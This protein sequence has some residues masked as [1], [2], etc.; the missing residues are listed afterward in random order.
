MRVPFHTHDDDDDDDDV[1][2]AGSAAIVTDTRAGKR[3]KYAG[4]GSE[5][6]ER[7][8]MMVMVMLG[9]GARSAS[10]LA[11]GSVLSTVSPLFQLLSP[12]RCRQTRF[13][14]QPQRGGDVVASE[15][16]HR[17]TVSVRRGCKDRSLPVLVP[18]RRRRERK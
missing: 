4:S 14:S 8:M 2:N 9:S 3:N 10:C 13:H 7:M 16:F 6:R 1:A 15:A 11:T 12:N 18:S 17:V 5:V